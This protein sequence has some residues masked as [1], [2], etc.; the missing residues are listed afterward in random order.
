MG[1]VGSKSCADSSAETHRKLQEALV[2]EKQTLADLRG[3]VN[4]QRQQL[5]EMVKKMQEMQE[6]R[7]KSD[8]ESKVRQ[9]EIDTLLRRLMAVI[10]SSEATR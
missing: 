3:L 2:S 7:K 4:I 1:I 5:D 10:P 9:A 8:E 6:E